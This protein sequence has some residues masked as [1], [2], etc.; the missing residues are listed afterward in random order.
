MKVINFSTISKDKVKNGS[1]EKVKSGSKE[2][3]LP[4]SARS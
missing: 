4:K 2:K 1:K 3:N